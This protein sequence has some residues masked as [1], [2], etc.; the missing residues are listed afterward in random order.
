MQNVKFS[1]DGEK[2]KQITEVKE[3]KHTPKQMLNVLDHVRNQI[4]QFEGS[5]TQIEQQMAT[6]KKNIRSAKDFEKDLVLFEE[7]C[8][9]LQKDKLLEIIAKI[10]DDCKAKAIVSS[11]K[12]IKEAP[13]AYTEEQKKNLPYLDYQKNL[14]TH[15]KIAQK[16][17][18]R[19]IRMYL[20]ETPLFKNPFI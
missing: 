11:N 4:Q 3:Q 12:I 5:K 16:I 1:W 20:Y 6:V 10:S 7:K 15:S 18:S 17:S 14:A 13:D 8:M 19:V 2:V 9:Q